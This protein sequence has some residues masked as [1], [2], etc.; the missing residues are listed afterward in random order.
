MTHH[1]LEKICTLLQASNL[2]TLENSFVDVD[3]TKSIEL[4][5]SR[6]LVNG[7]NVLDNLNLQR[8]QILTDLSEAYSYGVAVVNP[9]KRARTESQ[10]KSL[11]Y[12]ES[13]A[14]DLNSH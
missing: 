3:G 13:V 4:S 10:T 9:E 1:N 14:K 12:P 8:M 5:E 7:F 11:G 6:R 2:A